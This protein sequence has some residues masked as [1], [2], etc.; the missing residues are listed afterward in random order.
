MPLDVAVGDR[1]LFPDSRGCAG[2]DRTQKILVVPCIL[3]FYWIWATGWTQLRVDHQGL[4]SHLP[5]FV[6]G[7]LAAIL[8]VK[9]DAA[10]MASKD[11]SQ[12]PILKWLFVMIV[13]RSLD[14]GIRIAAERFFRGL[15]YD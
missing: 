1:L 7:S 15:L 3:L 5:T 12:P 14:F 4:R 10:A 8:Y 13:I 6:C 2:R 11:R 9:L